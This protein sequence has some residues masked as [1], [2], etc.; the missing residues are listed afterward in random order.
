M[1][2][3]KGFE[4]FVFESRKS[5][6]IEEGLMAQIDTLIHDTEDIEEF[7]KK[8]FKE[9]GSK[10][11]K[12]SKSEEWVRSLYTGSTNESKT[13]LKFGESEDVTVKYIDFLNEG[14]LNEAMDVSDDLK[15]G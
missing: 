10:V 3:L 12:N 13:S 9:Y 11:K 4:E 15:K 8:F 6:L 1:K 7:V 2:E 5:A 14:T